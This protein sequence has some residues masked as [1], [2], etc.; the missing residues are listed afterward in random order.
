MHNWFFDTH[1]HAM[2]LSHPNLIAFL[3]EVDTNFSELVIS[4]MFSPN[5]IASRRDP[6]KILPKV[7]NMLAVMDRPIDEIFMLME[8]DLSGFFKQEESET[9]GYEVGAFL[10]NGQISIRNQSYDRI[11]FCPMVMDFSQGKVHNNKIY[12]HKT[13]Q[14]KLDTYIQDTINGIRGFHIRRP[15]SIIR[16]FPFLGINPYFHSFEYLQ[17]LIEKYVRIPFLPYDHYTIDDHMFYGIK[18]YPPLG[19]DPWPEDREEKEKLTYIYRFC[20][21]KRVPITTHCDDQGFRT[22]PPK[23]SWNFTS[24]NR[25][26]LVLEEF[27]DLIIDF[28]H[29]GRQYRPAVNLSLTKPALLAN[30]WFHDIIR[31]MQKFEYVFADFSFSGATPQFYKA[32]EMHLKTLP[33][34]Q[35][36]RVLQR[37]LFGSDFMVNLSKVASYNQ[38]YTIFDESPFPDDAIHK[39]VSENPLSFVTGAYDYML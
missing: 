5:Y 17:K 11:G 7:E 23:D 3:N 29:Y 16:F 13:L 10:K 26:E 22:I 39:F 15:E 9:A 30:P 24:P 12:Y 38:F 36:Q 6:L 8:D 35:M 21:K 37:S 4:G 31:L 25:W 1:F 33:P 18:I 28:A 19:F 27:P 34:E 2:T 20:E 14:N 32:L